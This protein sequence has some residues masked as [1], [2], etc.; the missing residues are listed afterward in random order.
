MKK[1][2]IIILIL[3]FMQS[4]G[5]VPMYS[6]NQKVDFYIQSI[7][8]NSSD[9]ELANFIK[10]DLNNYLKKKTGKNFIITASINYQKTVISKS[11]EAIAEEYNLIS[12]VLFQINSENVDKEI[13]IN[14]TYKMNNFNDEFEERKY[15]QTIKK[16]MARSI[17]SKL[18]IQLTRFNVN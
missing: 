4:C 12:T 3:F 11:A 6:K 13:A 1:P 7:N 18:I 5:Y 8:F 2:S 14:E 10:S 15:E 16:N 9:R 17:V